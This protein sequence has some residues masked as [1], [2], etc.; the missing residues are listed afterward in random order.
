MTDE[1]RVPFGKRADGTI[2]HI[3]ELT[4]AENGL[5]CG[6]VCPKCGTA[7]QARN[8]GKLRVHHFSHNV[9][10]S[11]E[12]A[13]ES[14]LHQ[15]AKEVFSRHTSVRV[16]EKITYVGS[17]S[18][19]VTETLDV[20]Y[21][22]VVTERPLGEIVP[23]VTLERAGDK[24]SLLVEV[25][26]THFADED[27]CAK[28]ESLGYPCIEVDLQ[29]MASL[30]E[31]DQ[32]AVEKALVSEDDRKIWLFH[33]LEAQTRAQLEAD[34]QEDEEKRARELHEAWERRQRAAE[35]KRQERARVLAPE[36][37]QEMNARRA[38][39]LPTHPIWVANKHALGIPDTAETPWSQ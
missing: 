24:P 9:K 36:Y 14:A 33:P 30:E 3:T 18:A 13:V 32:E 11:C 4:P 6:C 26:V 22:G 16:P 35:R 31:F 1:L 8:M 20:P 15:F 5:R 2:M 17:H 38:R 12:G 19:L 10:T 21:I 37:Q 39:E 28:P 23:D 25:A 34:L 27:K 7:L 29:D